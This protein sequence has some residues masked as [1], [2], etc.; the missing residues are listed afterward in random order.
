MRLKKIPDA[1]EQ[2]RQSNFLIENFP[3]QIDA[4]WIVEIGMGKGDMLVELARLSPDKKF[5][6]IEKFDSAAVKAIKK[7]KKYNLTNFFIICSDVKDI[8]EKISGTTD[9]IWLTFSDPWPKKRHLKRRLTYKDFLVIYK[10]LL[11]KEGI[12]KLKTDN[13]GFFEYSLESLTEFGAQILYKTTN[14][15]ADAKNEDNIFT[16]YEIKWSQKDK[17]INYLEAKF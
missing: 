17:N 3:L 7:A 15:H 9:L 10:N 13:D 11:S 8:L 14:L 1:L 12:L 2:L 6:G 5:L 4:D 16:D